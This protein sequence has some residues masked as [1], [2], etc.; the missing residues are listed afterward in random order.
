MMADIDIK[1]VHFKGVAPAT[2]DLLGGHSHAM[3]GSGFAVLPHV[4]SGKL[5]TLATTGSKRSSFFPDAPTIMESGVPKYETNQW[6][7]ILAPAGTPA[8]IGDRLSNEI[9]TI[10][11]MDEMKKQF[12][13]AGAEADYAGP[14]EFGR[15]IQQ[16]IT[17]W[18]DIAKRANIQPE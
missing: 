1:I 13:D 17:K 18:Q 9:K 12:L 8:S 15:L 14:S 16:E 3:F 10:L 11:A 2:V 7:G 6:Y 5:R 4:K